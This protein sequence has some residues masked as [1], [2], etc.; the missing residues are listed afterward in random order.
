MRITGLSQVCE[1]PIGACSRV[2]GRIVTVS[3]DRC[4]TKGPKVAFRSERWQ[5]CA[6]D[7]TPLLQDALP[8]SRLDLYGLRA[9]AF[10]PAIPVVIGSVPFDVVAWAAMKML[11]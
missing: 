6:H 3:C 1:G 9:A 11:L 7:M 8:V 4:G 5:I 10:V 2:S